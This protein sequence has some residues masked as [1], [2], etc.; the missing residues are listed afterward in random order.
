MLIRSNRFSVSS[1]VNY[2]T[3]VHI[4]Y[5]APQDRLAVLHFFIASNLACAAVVIVFHPETKGKSLEQMDELF[6]D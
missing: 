2:A 3:M 4:G 1:I 5:R 6:G